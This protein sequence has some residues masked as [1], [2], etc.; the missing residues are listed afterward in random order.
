MYK[1]STVFVVLGRKL[2][3]D[4]SATQ[5][6][7]ERV[8][9]ACERFLAHRQ[10]GDRIVMTGA[11]V[12]DKSTISEALCMKHLAQKF[13][14]DSD[15]VILEEQARTTIENAFY[16][17]DLLQSLNPSLIVIVT[18]AYHMQRTR[19]I[20][21]RILGTLFSRVEYLPSP[22][23]CMSPAEREHEERVE[24]WMLGQLDHHL[25]MY[26]VPSS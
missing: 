6:L 5:L 26:L 21:E 18:S 16:V 20:F 2:L 24:Q 25:G 14:V 19:L 7:I 4:G 10:R 1:M 13:G 9:V 22:D 3:P 17:R 15:S 11:R 8:R 23:E 12:E